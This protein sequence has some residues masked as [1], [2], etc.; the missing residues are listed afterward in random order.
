M[1]GDTSGLNYRGRFYRIAVDHFAHQ[2]RLCREH[3][4]DAGHPAQ[5][6]KIGAPR[7]HFHFNPQLISWNHRAAKT[8]VIY[9]DKVEQFSVSL[10][11]FFQK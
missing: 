10:R 4:F 7:N 2:R 1:S 3:T 8:R 6:A 11:D 5:F 9:R